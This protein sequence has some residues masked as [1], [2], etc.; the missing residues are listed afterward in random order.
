MIYGRQ[1]TGCS[2]GRHHL[3]LE[4]NTGNNV[5]EKRSQRTTDAKQALNKVTKNLGTAHCGI[6][7]PAY[8]SQHT[9]NA[10]H[11]VAQMITF[12]C[13]TLPNFHND[14]KIYQG[15]YSL[16]LKL[17]HMEMEM[18]SVQYRII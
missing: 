4:A 6:T 13:T 11:K 12:P 16:Y 10:K 1:I 17:Q 3:R 5:E 18:L 7:T 2:F 14:N 9:Y 8:Y 15:R